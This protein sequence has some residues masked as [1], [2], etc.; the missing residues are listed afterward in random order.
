[1]L[2]WKCGRDIG[3]PVISRFTVCEFC[4]ADLHCCKQCKFY[5]QNSHF[6]C[7]ENIIDPISEKEKSN[8]CEFFVKSDI[9]IFSEDTNKTKKS[10]SKLFGD[11]DSSIVERKNPKDVFNALFGD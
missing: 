9:H 2:C 11:D 10:F 4:G 3:M 6:D 1:M 8:F 7:K 5:S